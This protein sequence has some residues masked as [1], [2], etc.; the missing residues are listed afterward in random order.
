MNEFEQKIYDYLKNTSSDVISEGDMDIFIKLIALVFGA[1]YERTKKLPWQIDVDHVDEEYLKSLSSLIG[2]PWS[3]KLTAE[4]QRESIKLYLLI[5]KYRGTKFGLLNLIRV[6]GQSTE[7]YYSNSDLRGIEVVEYNANIPLQ[8]EPNMYPGDIKVKIPE[9]STI[10]RDALADTQLAG[11]RI[12]FVYCVFLGLYHLDMKPG[13]WYKIN[14]HILPTYNERSNIIETY[15]DYGLDE[16]KGEMRQ[17]IN[18]ILGR[19]WAWQITHRT[20]GGEISASSQIL[21]Y[22]KDPWTDGFF[23]AEPGLTN[24]RGFVEEDGTIETEKVIYE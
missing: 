12:T 16:S 17:G 6:F 13:I 19:L 21:T 7:T 15:G 3:D 8:S 20:K 10:L 23:L 1:L 22:H 18:T 2:Y 5:R 9:L 11:T 14:K 4:Q 24:Y